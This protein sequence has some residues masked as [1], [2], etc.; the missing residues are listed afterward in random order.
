MSISGN[1]VHKQIKGKIREVETQSEDLASQLYKVE[2][3]LTD[4]TTERE[5]Y[6]NSLAANY[7]PEFDAQ[8][9]Q[10][11]L[12]EVRC[13]VER[14][15]KEKQERRST[16]EKLMKE[17]RDRNQKL[18]EEIDTV[19]AQIEQQAQ[20]RDKT[21]E[22]ISGDLQ[23][24][25]N[26]TRRDEEA[27]KAEVR[28]QQ[29][30]KRVEEIEEEASKKLPAF[31]QN[32]IFSYLL[33]S[34][35]GTSQYKR[36][37]LRKRLDSWVTEK[38]NFG[39]NK[40]CYD[41]LKSMPEMMKQ[42]VARRQ[43]EL[44]K[45]V[46]EMEEIES[47]V[48]KQYGLPKIVTQAEKLIRKRQ[49][50]IGEDKKQDEQYVVYVKEREEIDSKKDPYHIQAV[51]QVKSFLQGEQIADLRS[52]ARQTKG[53]EDDKL[54]DKIDN[55]DTEIQE[56]KDKAKYVRSERDATSKKLDELRG[57]EKRFRSRDYEGSYSSFS[58]GF[59]VNTLLIRYILG[60]I[61]S[62]DVNKQI[63]SSQHTRTQSY[64]SSNDYSSSRRSSHSGSSGFGGFG[65]F[66][67]GG[68]FGGR[69]GFSSGKGF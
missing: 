15:F 69:G 56:L 45:I 53:T 47:N 23:K 21:I 67:S 52:R 28:L 8:T 42:E 48:E 12:R 62:S 68:G 22:L 17:N 19:T 27:K 58:D 61:T 20:E 30:K 37:G 49:T 63:D 41:F 14:V 43:E 1:S 31:E 34:D 44:D 18:E 33:K 46:S 40:K 66:S 26:Y 51:Q 60:K 38:V 55:M 32:K 39:E 2:Q 7:L 5:S 35:Y 57:I 10:T 3:H 11:T 9:V 50:A 13:E 36:S 4:L 64:H 25:A 24:D 59:D 29:Y 65:G 16:L 6:Y 54:V